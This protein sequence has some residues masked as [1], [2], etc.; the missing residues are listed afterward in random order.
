MLSLREEFLVYLHQSESCEQFYNYMKS[1]QLA[2]VLEFYLA[3]D[4]LKNLTDENKSQRTIIDLIYKHYLSTGKSLASKQFSLPYDLLHSIKQRLIK[5][6]YY[7]TFYEHAQ[8]YVLKYMLQMC[9][10]KFLVEQHNA[11]VKKRQATDSSRFTPMHRCCIT[12]KKKD[13]FD[14]FKQQTNNPYEGRTSIKENSKRSE[15]NKNKSCDL[16]QRN[17]IAFFEELQRRLVVYQTKVNEDAESFAILDRQ[18]A[19]TIDDADNYLNENVIINR[20]QSQH[21]IRHDS[22]MGTDIS[23]VNYDLTSSTKVRSFI[24]VIWY[25]SLDSNHALLSTIPY[26][27]RHF[28]FKEFRELFKKHSTYRYFFK[29]ICTPDINKEQ[30]VYRELIMDDELVPFYDGKIFVQL[31]RIN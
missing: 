13:V 5:R 30:Y 27:D 4:G 2:P 25:S 16:A 15:L 3:C 31:D 12:T 26:R 11:S 18:I 21:L 9:Y 10:P 22:G 1:E 23:E 7:S 29:T 24:D 8:E 28:T 20:N 6:E 17:P 14:K 19:Q